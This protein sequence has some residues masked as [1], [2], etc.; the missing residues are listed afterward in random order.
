MSSRGSVTKN[1]HITTSE[2]KKKREVLDA[3]VLVG[4]KDQHGLPDYSHTPNRIY[5]KENKDGSFRE[6]RIYEN[7]FPVLEISYHIEPNIS[8]NRNE[9][10]LHYHTFDKDLK[11]GPAREFS[12]KETPELFAK[13][14]KYLEEYG[15]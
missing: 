4:Q 5:I 15:L 2:Y 10:I 6:M 14:K 7:S 1:G 3:K 11:R 13:Y 12:K 8:G 9:K